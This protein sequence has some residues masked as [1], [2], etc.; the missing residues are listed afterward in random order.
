MR[1]FF[2]AVLILAFCAA[3]ALAADYA[4]PVVRV[5][6]G[7]T[8]LVDAG[9]DVPPELAAIRVRLRGVDVPGIGRYADCDAE[10]EA[11]LAAAAFTADVLAGA[12]AVAVR[13]PAWG[14]WGGGRVIADLIVDGRSLAHTLIETGHGRPYDG[15]RRGSWCKR[16][17]GTDD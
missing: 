2:K 12:D 17:E 14:R 13:D 4:W 11:G 6:D 1:V 3:P 15:G 10:R 16:T 9:A 8:V 7:D 5:V